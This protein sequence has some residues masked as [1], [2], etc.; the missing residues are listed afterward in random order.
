QP[1]RPR[2]DTDQGHVVPHL[3]TRESTIYDLVIAEV[4]PTYFVNRQIVDGSAYGFPS[5]ISS[6]TVFPSFSPAVAANVRSA[7]AVRPW[8]PMTRPSSPDPT[9]NS[10]NVVP[11]CCDSTTCTAS[12]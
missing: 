4:L 11:R 3:S 2:H 6:V 10:I 7:A 9:Y 12:G 1:V 5:R 8:R